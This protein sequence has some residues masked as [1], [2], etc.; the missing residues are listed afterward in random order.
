MVTH[1]L[2][3][4]ELFY[5]LALRQFATTP[6]VELDPPY[7]VSDLIKAHLAACE[8][9]VIADPAAAATD[10][11]AALTSKGAMLLEHR[12]PRGI[13]P[14]RTTRGPAAA[15]PRRVSSD[16]PR[17]SQPRLDSSDDPR[18]RRSLSPRT[19]RVVSAAAPRPVSAAA[20]RP[21][22]AAVPR[23]VS[24]E[25][26]PV[27]SRV[28]AGTSRWASTTTAGSR[29]CRCFCRVTCRSWR[30]SRGSSGASRRRR[31]GAT[32]GSASTT[33]ARPSGRLVRRS[34]LARGP[35]RRRRRRSNAA[36]TVGLRL[37]EFGRARRSRG[38]S[39]RSTA[40]S[41]RRTRRR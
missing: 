35:S 16:D 34:W 15:S 36:K 32:S 4:R 27:T 12:R 8:A 29:T 6:R 11:A 1:S 23:P 22:S 41:R 37:F 21:V 30:G 25:C 9:D 40:S 13:L 10:A 19:I 20:P 33:Y 5:Q 26:L 24:A 7:P 2:L 17:T 18:R 3:S 14:S 31:S 38:T 39:A 28:F